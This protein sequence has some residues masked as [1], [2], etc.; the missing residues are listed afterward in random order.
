MANII[1]TTKKD[2]ADRAAEAAGITK[3][4]AAA[5]VNAV[6]DALAET[7][8]D[9]GE[10]SISGFGK[11]VVAERSARQGVNPATGEKIEIAASKSPKFKP[12][13]A[14]KDAVK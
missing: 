9:G 11:F 6:F 2:L 10:A 8:K 7:L 14:L 13:K 1:V 12:A 3:K 4:E 5:A